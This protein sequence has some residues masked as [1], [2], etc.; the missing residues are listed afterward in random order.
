MISIDVDTDSLTREFTALQREQIPFAVSKALNAV[1]LDVQAREREQLRETFTLR[2]PEW[3]DRSVKI[4]HFAKKTELYTTVAIS[5][6]G[7]N[8]G[9]ILGKFETE[10]EK[11]ARDGHTIAIPIRARRNK[12]D[13]IVG[14]DRPKA[15]NFQQQ[16]GRIVGDRG[17]FLV[18]RPDGTGLILQRARRSAK[19]RTL[20]YKGKDSSVFA[21]YLLVP[22]AE[23]QPDLRFVPTAMEVVGRLWETQFGIAFDAALASAR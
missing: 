14:K 7:G 8:R 2:R 17:T 1:G 10:T 23:L 21:L 6:P 12:R 20:G 9:D 15:F 3:A 18:R 4:T 22:R 11:R 19:G 13:I 5:P 16:G